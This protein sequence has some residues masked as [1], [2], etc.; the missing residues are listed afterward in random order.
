[1]T[2]RSSKAGARPGLTARVALLLGSVSLVSCV[3]GDYNKFRIYQEPLMEAVDS[4][5]PGVTDL[6]SALEQLGAPLF[7]IEVGLGMS[8]A[9]GWQNTTD[10]NIEV[11]VP[12]GDAAGNFQY[13]D[14]S[15]QIQ[16][17]VLFFD[18]SWTMTSMQKGFLA[19]LVPKRQRPRDVDDDLSGPT[20]P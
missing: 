18:E 15:A 4:L 9:W 17:I 2:C 13:A 7:V 3:D 8:L 5:K 19:D 1:M 12:V 20:V 16:G 6:E 10:W 11:S 14:T